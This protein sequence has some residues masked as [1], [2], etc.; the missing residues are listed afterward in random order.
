MNTYLYTCQ[1][2]Y[3]EFVPTRR[4]IQK[5]CSDSCRSSHHQCNTRLQQKKTDSLN[6]KKETKKV[7]NNGEGKKKGKEKSKEMSFAGI[8][9]A[10]AGTA[11][12]DIATR[13]LTAE[14]NKPAT[15]GDLMKLLNRLSGYVRIEDLE[16][17]LFGEKP[18][19]EI[20]TGKTIYR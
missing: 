9:N 11:F 13:L 2:C 10:A 7:K 3:Q 14:H 1:H 8:G 19:L 17:N 5:F 4:G 20:E 12:V 16:P 18:Y 6:G 15:K